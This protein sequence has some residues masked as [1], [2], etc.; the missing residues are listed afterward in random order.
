MLSLWATNHKLNIFSLENSLDRAPPRN[1]GCQNMGVVGTFNFPPKKALPKER[2]TQ[3]IICFSFDP[4]I[5]SRMNSQ[6][7]M[8]VNTKVESS[9]K[10]TRLA[11]SYCSSS[12]TVPE[13]RTPRLA[14]VWPNLMKAYWQTYLKFVALFLCKCLQLW[15]YTLHQ[16]IPFCC[17]V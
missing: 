5:A 3:I 7:L 13:E 11:S 10:R 15:I 8:L 16:C 17:H 2:L 4:S 12:G 1:F 9:S 14:S 6:M